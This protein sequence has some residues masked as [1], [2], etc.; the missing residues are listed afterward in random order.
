[1]GLATTL[2]NDLEYIS[3]KVHKAW[4]VDLFVRASNSVAIGFYEKLGYCIHRTVSG[5]YSSGFKKEDAKDMRKCMSI[6]THKKS[7]ICKKKVIKPKEL[8]WNTI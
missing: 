3:D 2:M 5:Y 4:F 7:L 8:E 6:D 1:M